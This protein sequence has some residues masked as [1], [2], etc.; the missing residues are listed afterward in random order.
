MYIAMNEV[1][2][3]NREVVDVIPVNL[4]KYMCNID[5][6]GAEEIRL[7]T[8][9][10]FTVRFPDGVYYLSKNAVFSDNPVNAVIINDMHMEELIE[11][12]TKSSLYSVKDEICSG[13]VTIS[14]GHRVGIAGT[15]VI[16]NGNIEFIKNISAVNIRIANEVIG[17]ADAITE[18]IT[19]GGVKSTLI[20]S[21]PC[22]GKTTMLRDI[23]RSLSYMGYSVAVADER[24]E[25]AAMYEG[26]SSFDLGNMTAVLDNC[27]KP[28]AMLMLLRSMSPEVIVTDEIGTMRDAEAIRSIMNSGVAVI[29]S[30]HGRDIKQLIKRKT[31]KNLIPMFDA[32]VTLSRRNGAGTIEEIYEN[33]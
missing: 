33:A 26:K 30:I 2:L 8:G 6:C 4:R 27:P 31:L 9:K 19:S 7:I 15:A 12:I 1:R 29:A 3:T 21:P 20:I 28:E 23:T 11:R 14:G 10:P 18:R 24:C 32:V 25:I 22:A 16:D 17:A 5:L 13:Y